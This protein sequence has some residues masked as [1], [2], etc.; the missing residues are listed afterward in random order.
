[1]A[2]CMV[3]LSGFLGLLCAVIISGIWEALVA[4]SNNKLLSGK[5]G[6]I[7]SYAVVPFVAAFLCFLMSG[8]STD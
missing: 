2:Y 8:N 7:L 3:L 6:T 4:R 5:I 1:M